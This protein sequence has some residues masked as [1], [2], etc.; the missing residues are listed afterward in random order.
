LNYSGA[1]CCGC[2]L[3]R[4]LQSPLLE[5]ANQ[6]G[7]ENGR[8]FLVWIA[9]MHVLHDQT[10]CTHISPNR[11]RPLHGVPLISLDQLSD[12]RI[13]VSKFKPFGSAP[14]VVPERFNYLR[15][16]PFCGCYFLGSRA[17]E[18]FPAAPVDGGSRKPNM[19]IVSACGWWLEK[20]FPGCATNRYE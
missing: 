6:T 1:R 8:R 14:S 19:P 18:Y 5:V 9:I 20:Y 13:I 16:D 11:P 4:S 3:F 2:A 10:Q 12:R 15:R 17:A 7:G